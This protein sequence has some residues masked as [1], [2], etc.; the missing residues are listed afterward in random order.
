M[1]KL[2]KALKVVEIPRR[3]EMAKLN[4]TKEIVPLIDYLAT[5]VTFKSN[6]R[7]ITKSPQHPL[8]IVPEENLEQTSTIV[9][10]N[11]DDDPSEL[12]AHNSFNT[13]KRSPNNS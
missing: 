6:K 5:L 7:S 8:V 11:K 10:T 9:P 12:A 2:N 4:L 1:L 13:F 3:I